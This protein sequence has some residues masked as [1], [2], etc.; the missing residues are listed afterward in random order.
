MTDINSKK[1]RLKKDG[2]PDRRGGKVGNKGNKHATG[3]KKIAGQETR[4]HI[5]FKA[6][7]KEYKLLLQ[8]AHILKSDFD[9]GIEILD[10]AGLVPT[11]RAKKDSSRK[12]RVTRVLER[13]KK[14]IR[15]MLAIIKDRYDLIYLLLNSMTK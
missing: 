9:K 13:E 7:E 8:Y 10:K 11:G 6:N 15:A 2:T 14:P 4:K 3:R 12:D 5:S 1:I